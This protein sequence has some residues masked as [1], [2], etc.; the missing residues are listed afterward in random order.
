MKM[1]VPLCLLL[2][3][4]ALHAAEVNKCVGANGNI[5]LTDEPCSSL[6]RKS[7]P[8]PAAAAQPGPLE[9]PKTAPAPPIQPIKAL[10]ISSTR[11]AGLAELLKI[12]I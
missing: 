5:M 6:S 4:P 12:A 1:L 2:T 9:K 7:A 8:E 3:V 10:R 11:D